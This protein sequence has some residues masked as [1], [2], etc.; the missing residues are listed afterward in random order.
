VPSLPEVVLFGGPVPIVEAAAA[1][2][3]LLADTKRYYS[4]SDIVTTLDWDED[5]QPILKPVKAAA[6]ASIFEDFAALR[7][8]A[9]RNGEAVRVPTTASEQDAKMISSSP[10][11]L[12]ELPVIRVLTNCP[13]LIERGGKLVQ[14]TGYD[15]ESGILAAGD[16]VPDVELDAAIAMLNELLADFKF[17]TPSDRSRAL[18]SVI[19]PTFV[20]G[21]LLRGRAP[22]DLGEANESQ[23]GKGFKNKIV[24]AIHGAVLKTVT[25]RRGGVGSL[26]ESFDSALV[27]GRTFISL[28]NIRGGIDLP[29]VESFVTEDRYLARVPY[30]PAIEVDPRRTIIMMTSNKAEVTVDLANRS[31]CTRILKQDRR[32]QFRKYPEGDVLDNVRANQPAYLGAVFAVVRAWHAAGK[33]RTQECRHDFRLWAQTLDWIVQNVLHA[34]PLLAGHRETQARIANPNLNWLRDVA[35]AVRRAGYLGHWGRASNLIDIISDSPEVEMPGLPEG[36]EVSDEEV[37]KKVLQALGRKLALCFAGAET[38]TIDD[39]TITRRESIDSLQ[40]CVKEYRF[41]IDVNPTRY[42]SEGHSG[43]IGGTIAENSGATVQEGAG[44]AVP[45]M[46]PL[47]EPIATRY[48]KSAN[49]LCPAIPPIASYSG[50]KTGNLS[51]SDGYIEFRGS[52]SGIADNKTVKAND[53]DGDWTQ[54]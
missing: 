9:M 14:I 38:V 28:D 44:P 17:A 43:Y 48:A 6:L 7:K 16:P 12:R 32:Y 53:A 5:Q 27:Q 15:A 39:M 40:R 24:A 18:A 25:Q 22:V 33:P 10:A 23:S 42:G 51:T 41:E 30:Q 1:L 2:G 36:A 54:V 4:R 50:I 8:L 29:N 45:A 31:S 37:R 49:P 34:T 19:T 35:L 52:H 3:K 20:L 21:G 13:V 47:C 26:G 11:F 46:H